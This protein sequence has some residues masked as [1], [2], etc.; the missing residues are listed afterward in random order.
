MNSLRVSS[1]KVTELTGLWQYKK[2]LPKW[3]RTGKKKKT[4]VRRI[5]F[6]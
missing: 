4:E 6:K 5:K 1:R 2:D 3:E